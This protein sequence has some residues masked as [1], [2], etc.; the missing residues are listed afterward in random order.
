MNKESDQL[1]NRG[2]TQNAQSVC[3]SRAR[4]NLSSISIFLL[5]LSG[6]YKL[7]LSRVHEGFRVDGAIMRSL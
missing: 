1:G 7:G 5:A 4:I 6:R 2:Q 3:R